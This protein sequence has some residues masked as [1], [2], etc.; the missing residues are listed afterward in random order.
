MDENAFSVVIPKV[1]FVKARRLLISTNTSLPIAA[2][3]MRGDAQFIHRA[4]RYEAKKDSSPF[5]LLTI[6]N[7]SQHITPFSLPVEKY[8]TGTKSELKRHV[9][10]TCLLD[11][12]KVIVGYDHGPTQVSC[13]VLNAEV[14]KRYRERLYLFTLN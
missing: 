13:I 10:D 12:S 11:D 2:I 9:I 1:D 14:R 7:N 6:F 3:G 4:K 8:H 5:P